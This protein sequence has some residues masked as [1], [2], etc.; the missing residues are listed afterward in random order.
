MDASRSEASIETLNRA[1]SHLKDLEATIK[2]LL[3]IR[4]QYEK[5]FGVRMYA[6]GDFI[7]I[8]A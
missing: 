2:V 5:K 8:E 3:A 7:E 4:E 1:Q 6:N